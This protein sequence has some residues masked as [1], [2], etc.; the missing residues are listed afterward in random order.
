MFNIFYDEFKAVALKKTDFAQAF[1]ATNI[2]SGLR[3]GINVVFTGVL[4]L[5]IEGL[6]WREGK[7]A[8]CKQKQ[9]A[10]AVPVGR[11]SPAV[12]LQTQIRE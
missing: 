5:H 8:S 3:H 9:R 4:A 1:C 6:L 10:R 2:A 7:P 11:S 12:Y